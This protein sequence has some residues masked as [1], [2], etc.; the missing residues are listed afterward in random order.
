MS[1]IITSSTISFGATSGASASASGNVW[2]PTT[3]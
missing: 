2:Q 1:G 3:R